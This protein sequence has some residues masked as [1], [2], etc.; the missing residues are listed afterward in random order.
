M[1]EQR[2]DDRK[3]KTIGGA[4]AREA[5]P[6]VMHPEI[7]EPG[8]GAH[9]APDFRQALVGSRALRIREDPDRMRARRLGEQFLG[10]P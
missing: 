8:G 7:I 2:A 3:R 5:V 9:L 1:A 10:G 4:E 6:Q